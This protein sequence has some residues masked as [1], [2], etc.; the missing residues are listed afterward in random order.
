MASLRA[1]LENLLKLS[2]DQE[3]LMQDLKTMDINNPQ[4]LKA[5]QE[6]RNLKDDAKMIE[7]SLFA[8]SKRVIQI[9]SV[10]NQEIGIINQNMEKALG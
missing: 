7:D 8:L 2:F 10:V 3:K 4:Y 6:Q 1:L 5:S 9:K